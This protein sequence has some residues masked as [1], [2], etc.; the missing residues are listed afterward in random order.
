VSNQVQDPVGRSYRAFR[1]HETKVANLET[2]L[3]QGGV[4]GR[5]GTADSLDEV[6]DNFID[7]DVDSRGDRAEVADEVCDLRSE[8]D[9]EL[10]ALDQHCFDFILGK[11]SAIAVP[12]GTS[13]YQ[14]HVL[15]CEPGEFCF[16]VGQ[17]GLLLY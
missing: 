15:F 12:R 1:V 16:D 8:V 9:D 17:S 3:L 14:G 11:R 10:D 7:E 5:H 13:A 2:T 4:V 6:D